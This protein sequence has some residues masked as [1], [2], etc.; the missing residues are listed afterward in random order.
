MKFRHACNFV[1]IEIA[2]AKRHSKIDEPA[3]AAPCVHE[4]KAQ[5]DLTHNDMVAHKLSRNIIATASSMN[6][7]TNFLE[8][9]SGC[10]P[11]LLLTTID[12]LKDSSYTLNKLNSCTVKCIPK[13][14]FN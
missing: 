13:Y 1:T 2:M 10:W 14:Q 6:N 9:Q 4:M 11:K 7:I 5:G 8:F 3:K 12:K